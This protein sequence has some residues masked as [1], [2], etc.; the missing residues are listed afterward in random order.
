LII[1]RGNEKMIKKFKNFALGFISAS[2]IFCG[3]A[4]ASQISETVQ[5]TFKDIKIVINGII[6]QKKLK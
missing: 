3:L 4:Y 6:Y 1:E 2:V 5:R